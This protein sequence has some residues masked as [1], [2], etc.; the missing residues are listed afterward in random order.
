MRIFLNRFK[1]AHF[2]LFKFNKTYL[3]N[4]FLKTLNPNNNQDINEE[5]DKY[6]DINPQY[7][8]TKHTLLKS[9]FMFGFNSDNIGYILHETTQNILLGIDF[10]EFEVS[11]KLS[12]E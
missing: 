8:Y 6:L 3:S 2:N 1:V 11:K 7:D 4:K 9:L 5:S 12:R 10:G